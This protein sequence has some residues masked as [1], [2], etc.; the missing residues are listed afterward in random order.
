MEIEVLPFAQQG[1]LLR[2][3]LIS[4]RRRFSVAFLWRRT[5]SL[6]ATYGMRGKVCAEIIWRVG[7]TLT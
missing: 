4:T 7:L 6:I 5:N 2:A 1:L 3:R